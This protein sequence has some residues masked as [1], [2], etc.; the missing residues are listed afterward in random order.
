MAVKL[1]ADRDMLKEEARS[2]D[3]R[4]RGRHPS[5]A[6]KLAARAA[7]RRRPATR[8]STRGPRVQRFRL[9]SVR[10]LPATEHTPVWSALATQTV[11][12][13]T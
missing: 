5:A 8:M 3:L 6:L 9:L 13:I 4:R 10:I 11:R 12:L 1:T 7:V 2:R